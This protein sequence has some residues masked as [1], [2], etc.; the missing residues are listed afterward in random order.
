MRTARRSSSAG[1]A[2]LLIVQAQKHL[3][4]LAAG[5]NVYGAEGI[6]LP[7]IS[8]VRAAAL[9][10]PAEVLEEQ[11]QQDHKKRLEERAAVG[12]HAAGYRRHILR[13]RRFLED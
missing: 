13:W 4:A 11:R 8:S 10:R 12:R 3:L 1:G 5:A 7:A 2:V 6:R 9:E